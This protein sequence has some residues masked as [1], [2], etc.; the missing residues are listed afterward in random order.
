M[1][2]ASDFKKH[3]SKTLAGHL[4][5]LGFK[6]SGFNYLM[7]T[8]DFVFTIGVQASQWGGQCCAEFG[9]QPKAIDGIG[10]YKIDFRKLKY[11]ECE[12]RTR[13]T[14]NNKSDQWWQYSDD[15]EKNIQVANEMFSI[16]VNQAVPIMDLFKN[17]DYIFDKIEVSDL[18][19]IYKNVSS[20]LGGMDLMTTDIRLAWALT[21]IYEKRD[22]ARAKQFARFG[23]SKLEPTSTF[24]GRTDFEKVLNAGPGE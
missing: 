7:D 8:D 6:G 9:I 17:K 2:A 3:I 15:P 20:K 16:V 1:I 4:R 19:N 12:F 22:V 5:T 23:L 11:S 14:N 18:D 10:E 13:L 21:K 24:I